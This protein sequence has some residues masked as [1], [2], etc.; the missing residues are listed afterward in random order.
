MMGRETSAVEETSRHIPRGTLLRQSSIVVVLRGAV[1]WLGSNAVIWA[2]PTT[3]RRLTS[4]SKLRRIV[5]L[6]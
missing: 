6:S 3:R 4:C 2:P 1:R 5:M